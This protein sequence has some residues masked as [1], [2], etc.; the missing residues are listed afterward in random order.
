MMR[1]EG[2]GTTLS[3]SFWGRLRRRWVP[4]A[5]GLDRFS[6]ENVLRNDESTTNGVDQCGVSKQRNV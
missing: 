5:G 4:L 2:F 3:R 6:H 1:W